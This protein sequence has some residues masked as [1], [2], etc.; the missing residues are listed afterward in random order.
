MSDD[1]EDERQPELA[2]VKFARPAMSGLRGITPLARTDILS[3]IV[4]TLA[5]GGRQGVHSHSAYEGFYFALSGRARFYGRDNKFFA[6]IGPNEAVLVP[7]NTPYAFEAAGDKE[8]QLLAI[9]VQDAGAV[10]DF[11][12]YEP[13]ADIENYDL[14]APDGTPRDLREIGM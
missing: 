5:P 6:E 7:R 12:G 14:Y 4:Q 2:L 9:N 13:G 11:K 10:D 1:R 8:V 3:V